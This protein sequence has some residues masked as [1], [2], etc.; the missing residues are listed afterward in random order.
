MKEKRIALR[1]LRSSLE[2][3]YGDCE[4]MGLISPYI[5]SALQNE[6][7]SARGNGADRDRKQDFFH[8]RSLLLFR[9]HLLYAILPDKTRLVSRISCLTNRNRKWYSF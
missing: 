3:K 6:K 8:R 7:R 2:K 9:I 4:L 5:Q 1:G